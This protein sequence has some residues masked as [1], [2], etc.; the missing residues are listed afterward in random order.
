MLNAEQAALVL[1]LAGIDPAPLAASLP[2]GSSATAVQL[3]RAIWGAGLQA[4]RVLSRA[5]WP[6]LSS[7]ERLHG[8]PAVWV[9][10]SF[11]CYGMR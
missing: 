4:V 10:V 8:R 2:R 9:M 6:R 5:L 11:K 3:V 1:A 7:T